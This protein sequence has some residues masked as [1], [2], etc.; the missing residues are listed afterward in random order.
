MLP[1][2]HFRY[3]DIIHAYLNLA[4]V[5]NDSTSKEFYNSLEELSDDGIQLSPK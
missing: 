1:L 4:R 3:I 5:N 2:N